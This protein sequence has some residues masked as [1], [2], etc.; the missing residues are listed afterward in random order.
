MNNKI[1]LALTDVSVFR[2]SNVGVNGV[3]VFHVGQTGNNGNVMPPDF[4]V[5][6]RWNF[7]KV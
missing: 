3:W 5:G 2:W 4:E 1:V 6:S 7:F